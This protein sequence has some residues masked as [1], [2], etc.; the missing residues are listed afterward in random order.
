MVEQRPGRPTGERSSAVTGIWSLICP[1]C[2]LPTRDAHVATCT[3][4]GSA[5]AVRHRALPSQFPTGAAR[6]VWRYRDW[7]P[8]APGDVAVTLQ[9]GATPMPRLR[10]WPERVGLDNVYAKLEYVAPTGSFKDRGAS[11][12]V[13]RALA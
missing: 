7:L 1:S 10:R 9:E 12:L 3:S 5:L 8:L 4:C 6:G 2:G 11:V 13:S